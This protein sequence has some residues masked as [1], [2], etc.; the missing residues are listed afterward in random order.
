MDKALSTSAPA[1]VLHWMFWFINTSSS[2]LH[3][4]YEYIERIKSAT[5]LVYSEKEYMFVRGSVFPYDLHTY[6]SQNGISSSLIYNINKRVFYS[7][8]APLT[9]KTVSL[10]I[11]SLEI[12]D[13]TDTTLYDISDFIES[14][15]SVNS[16]SETICIGHIISIWQLSSGTILDGSDIS[17]RYINMNGDMHTTDIRSLVK[18]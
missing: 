10:P 16:L 11:L 17:V 9:K 18:I 7:S 5:N 3:K 6:K 1:W 2:M 12:I 13:K 14:V 15:R 8:A 4:V